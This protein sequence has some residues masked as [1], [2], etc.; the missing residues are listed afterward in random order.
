MAEI[1]FLE[2]G[3]PQVAA[4]QLAGMEARS[5]DPGEGQIAALEPR[6]V[7]LREGEL[8]PDMPGIVGEAAI[9]EI[10]I[11][12]IDIGEASPNDPAI[13]EPRILQ[14]GARQP[15]I[16]QHAVLEPRPRQVGIAERVRGQVFATCHAACLQCHAPSPI[17]PG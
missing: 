4:P 9:L 3:P 2:N 8:N 13:A 14:A 7:E 11:A 10:G 1:H 17:R 5:L 15:D 16:A 6:L 12:Q